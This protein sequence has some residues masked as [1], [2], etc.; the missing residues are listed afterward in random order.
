MSIRKYFRLDLDYFSSPVLF[1]L[2]PLLPPLVY[3]LYCIL[4]ILV[5]LA[6]HFRSSEDDVR[7][8]VTSCLSL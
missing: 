3:S 8:P 1:A 6:S 5:L 2:S 7:T 4:N